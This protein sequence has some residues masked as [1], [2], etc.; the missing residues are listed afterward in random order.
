MLKVGYMLKY[1]KKIAC[2]LE[3]VVQLFAVLL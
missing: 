3:D 1:H 2:Q